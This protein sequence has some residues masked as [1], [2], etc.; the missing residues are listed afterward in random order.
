MRLRLILVAT[1]L[2]LAGTAYLGQGPR[3]EA[4]SNLPAPR[5]IPKDAIQGKPLSIDVELV[6]MDVVVADKNG[7]LIG[8]LEKRDFKVFDDGVEQTI[9]SFGANDTPLTVVIMFEFSKTLVYYLDDVFTPIVGFVN[10]LQENDW[11]ALVKVDLHT[12]ILTD[13]TKNKNLLFR[14]LGDLRFAT[15]NEVVLFDAVDEMLTRMQKI[16]GKKAI[17]IVATGID[18]ISKHT[19]GE[20]LKKAEAS[21][22]MI[23]SVSM[24]QL[25]RLYTENAR[26]PMDNMMFLAADN[27]LRSLSEVTGGQ[28]FYPRFPAEY[29]D[30]YDNISKQLRHQYSI[31]FAPANLKKD[32]K[33][34]K[35]R[36]EVPDLDLNKD[37]KKDGL[38]ARHK[39]GYYAPKS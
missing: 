11:A 7:T 28:A 24:G 33:F 35:L 14:P 23:Y 39:K 20:A 26:S 8:G 36:V 21:D 5:E 38:K 30:I 1:V 34:H 4:G 19:Y 10:S 25:Y 9:T 6:N 22:T 15:Y 17:F 37:G 18:T 16:D 2:L 29:P 31:G 32:G 13:F 12:E 27:Q 3:R